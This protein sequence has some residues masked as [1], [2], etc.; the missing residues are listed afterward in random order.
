MVEIN[1]YSEHSGI[2]LSGLSKGIL[3]KIAG[4]RKE[5]ERGREKGKRWEVSGGRKVVGWQWRRVVSY[6]HPQQLSVWV[7]SNHG[8]TGFLKAIYWSSSSDSDHSRAAHWSHDTHIHTHTVQPY[9]TYETTI[10]LKSKEHRTRT[11]THTQRQKSMSE[12]RKKNSGCCCKH[13]PS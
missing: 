1:R 10:L 12:K 9:E 5:K 6:G 4:R 8:L 11:N 13:S 7:A 2:T 3:A